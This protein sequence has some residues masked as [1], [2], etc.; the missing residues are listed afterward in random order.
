MVGILH[1]T[2]IIVITDKGLVYLMSKI[3]IDVSLVQIPCQYM[4]ICVLH[5][6][7]H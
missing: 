7:F 6:V 4:I 5:Q 1:D 2:S 3:K